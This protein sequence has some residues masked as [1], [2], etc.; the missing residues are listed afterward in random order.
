MG[1]TQGYRNQKGDPK[2]G[3]A[4]LGS[5]T[6]WWLITPM[7]GDPLP[8]QGGAPNRSGGGWPQPGVG[9][10]GPMCLDAARHPAPLA[11]WGPGPLAGRHAVCAVWPG[12]P[13]LC[14]LAFWGMGRSSSLVS[15]SP[16]SPDWSAGQWLPGHLGEAV[17]KLRQSRAYNHSR[18]LWGR[19]GA[20]GAWHP[21]GSPAVWL[22]TEPTL[23]PL[24]SGR[25]RLD[26]CLK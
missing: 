12:L 19:D 26:I 16:S 9:G 8:L 22:G 2:G 23:Q 25:G 13:S 21:V 5:L 1:K 10:P 15:V 7:L 20:G 17:G 24:I 11:P 4:L 3:P 14:T 18:S 6:T